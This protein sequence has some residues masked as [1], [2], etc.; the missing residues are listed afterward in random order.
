[1]MSWNNPSVENVAPVGITTPVDC[2][3]ILEWVVIVVIDNPI[4][5]IDGWPKSPHLILAI[6]A[7]IASRDKLLKQAFVALFQRP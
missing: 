4:F 1:M 3:A 6:Q 5:P 2:I 7:K